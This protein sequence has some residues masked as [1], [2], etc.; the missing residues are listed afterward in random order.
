MPLGSSLNETRRVGGLPLPLLSPLLSLSEE[1][2]LFLGWGCLACLLPLSTSLAAF[3][4]SG[5]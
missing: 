1:Q 5:P 2:L 4:G 3:S